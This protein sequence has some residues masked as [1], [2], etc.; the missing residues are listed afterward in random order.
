MR[1]IT[2]IALIALMGLVSSYKVS[3]AQFFGVVLSLTGYVVD[4]DTKEPIAM[5]VE[6]FDSKGN[7]IYYG[8]TKSEND[9]NYFITGLKPGADYTIKLSDNERY[10]DKV[11]KISM[12]ETDEYQEIAKDFLINNKFETAHPG[13]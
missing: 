9:G 1:K 13:K 4:S 8:R 12:P 6:A 11:E 10:A 3:E 7:R 2:I 5:R